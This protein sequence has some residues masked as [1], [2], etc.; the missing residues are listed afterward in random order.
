MA[1]A[2]DAR[3]VALVGTG[4]VGMSF[5][6]SLI[7]QGITDE[8]VLI[9][10]SREKTVGEAMDLNHGIAFAPTT[11]KIYAGSYADCEYVDIVVI[12]AGAPQLPGETRLDLTAKNAKII[13]SITQ[14]IM[15]NKFSG[16]IVVA[17]NPVDI[18][19]YVVQKVSGLPTAQVIGS[20]TVLDTSRLQ[21]LLGNYTGI[22][23]NSITAYVMAEHGDSSFIPWSNAYVGA[24]PL[25][26]YLED[27]GTYSEAALEDIYVQVRDAAYKIIEAKKAT[28][29][30]IGM[31]LARIVK[32]I[33]S[34]EAAIFTLSVALENHYGH[35][36]IYIGVPAVLGRT[37]VKELIELD[38]TPKDHEKLTKSITELKAVI[39]DSVEDI[40]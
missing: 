25:I 22:S 39:R 2:R 12:T 32:A 4:F 17:S 30:G 7:N 31:G 38:L 36:D 21:Y 35:N 23:S 18:M 19:T 1:T 26:K 37:G 24:K 11:T 27:K 28:Y 10:L 20:G 3:R 16:I 34:D 8:L 15:K 5:A 6:Y 40:L 14:E 33:F 9:D 29:Y 13:K